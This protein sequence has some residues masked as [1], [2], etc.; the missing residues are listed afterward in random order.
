M[1]EAGLRQVEAAPI[2]IDTV[3]TSFDDFWQPFLGKVG[4][5]SAY[6][7]S[8]TAG[9][10][11]AL[12]EHLRQHLAHPAGRLHCADRHR[13]GGQRHRLKRNWRDYP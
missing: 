4:L 13:L 10:R 9:D 7:L 3:F 1:T 8:L 5:A 2:T 12:M 11:Q 6:A